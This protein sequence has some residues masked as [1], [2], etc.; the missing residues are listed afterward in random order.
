MRLVFDLPAWP[1]WML[2]TSRM[3]ATFVCCGE[4]KGAWAYEK[5]QGCAERER[6]ACES[7]ECDD[8]GALPAHK[9]SGEGGARG[10][11]V[12]L[13]AWCVGASEGRFGPP[14]TGR[15]ARAPDGV[16]VRQEREEEASRG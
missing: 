4:E 11:G 14:A 5:S 1:M 16:T 15:P 2:I 8:A 10:S 7:L 3:L 9:R 6:T 13:Q 12:L